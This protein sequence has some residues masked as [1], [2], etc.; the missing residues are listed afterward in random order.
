[1]G[2]Y[3]I[4]NDV[5]WIKTEYKE[6]PPAV[7]DQGNAGSWTTC[8]ANLDKT[9]LPNYNIRRPL[10]T[11]AASVSEQGIQI[12]NSL[13]DPPGCLEFSVVNQSINHKLPWFIIVTVIQIRDMWTSKT[14]K[15]KIQ[16]ISYGQAK[17][18]NIHLHIHFQHPRP[19]LPY[20]PSFVQKAYN[21]K[22]KCMLTLIGFVLLNSSAQKAEYRVNVKSA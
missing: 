15:I 6:L 22:S 19:N 21:I 13:I 16:I 12:R 11:V 17:A 10:V 9:S 3:H 5:Q 8:R 2:Q 20:L 18:G 14:N 1:M 7:E 4:G